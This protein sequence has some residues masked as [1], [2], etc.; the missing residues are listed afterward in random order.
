MAPLPTDVEEKCKPLPIRCILFDIYGTLFISGSGDVGTLK[1]AAQTQA[2]EQAFRSV[3]LEEPDPEA[4]LTT[5]L[6]TIDEQHAIAKSQGVDCPEVDIVEVWEQTLAKR[7]RNLPAQQVWR[8][9]LEYECLANPVW[10]MP[11]A[12]EI[13]RWAK[14]AGLRLG[15]I[16]NAQKFTPLL[17]SAL[18]NH[19][20][21]ELGFDPDLVFFSYQ[22]RIAKPSVALY[23]LAQERLRERAI[24]AHQALYVGNDMLNDIY[25]AKRVGFRTALFAGDRRSLRLRTGDRRCAD[26]QPDLVL[27]DLSQLQ[28][29][30]APC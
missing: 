4:T 30:V 24:P 2:V 6:Q 25:A 11:H 7:G 10:P 17:F 27:T 23:Q 8:L 19:D 14:G 21:E 20:L 5:F 3:G 29:S 26:L 18:L 1:A 22:H 28:R 15:L 16:S 12:F 13:L 9:A